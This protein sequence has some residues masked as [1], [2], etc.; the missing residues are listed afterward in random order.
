[1]LVASA[2]Y[3]E[4]V[5]SKSLAIEASLLR[6]YSPPVRKIALIVLPYLNLTNIHRIQENPHV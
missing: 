4:S 3:I 6:K 2:Q 5:Q 1:M